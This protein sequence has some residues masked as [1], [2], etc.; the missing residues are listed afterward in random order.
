[1]VC[2]PAS[3]IRREHLPLPCGR[4]SSIFRFSGRIKETSGTYA[5]IGGDARKRL[6]SVTL[7]ML[8]LAK[9]GRESPRRRTTRRSAIVFRY[10]A[11]NAPP[12]I[13]SPYRLGRHCDRVHRGVAGEH[14]LSTKSGDAG[15]ASGHFCPRRPT[16]R[17][18][19]S[20]AE[21]QSASR[22]FRRPPRRP[23]SGPGR[24]RMRD[25]GGEFGEA[26]SRGRSRDCTG[27][28]Y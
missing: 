2:S 25:N 27:A 26:F 1:M 15:R 28:T 20:T 12:S 24:S 22:P 9:A 10:T 11:S 5:A 8:K 21:A 17:R 23:H 7:A 19:H 18:R 6:V 13:Q 16:A 14:R 3:A 4:T